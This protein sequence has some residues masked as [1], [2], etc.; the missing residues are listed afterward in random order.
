MT[1]MTMIMMMI[2]MIMMMIMMMMMI[3]IYKGNLQIQ[4]T[5]STKSLIRLIITYML[6]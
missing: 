5:K 4:F 1:M 6:P 2:M 3:E